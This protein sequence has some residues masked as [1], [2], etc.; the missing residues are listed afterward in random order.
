MRASS[1]PAI[2]GD[3]IDNQHQK[4]ASRPFRKSLMKQ[5]SLDDGCMDYE[6]EN[7]SNRSRCANYCSM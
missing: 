6:T 5:S 4:R 2:V 1:P 3:L 7:V